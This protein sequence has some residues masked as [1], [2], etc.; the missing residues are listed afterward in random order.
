MSWD[1]F[2]L[3]LC[4]SLQIEALRD[5]FLL[6]PNCTPFSCLQ[7][8]SSFTFS[9]PAYIEQQRL[10]YQPLTAVLLFGT[11]TSITFNCY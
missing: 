4:L 7:H 5:K 2:R 3:F 10:I 11:L 1:G 9:T 6:G 8:A